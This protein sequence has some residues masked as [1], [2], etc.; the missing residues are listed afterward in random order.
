LAIATL[1]WTFRFTT[2]IERSLKY[3]VR[4]KIGVEDFGLSIRV[5]L[6]TGEVER[7]NGSHGLKGVPDAWPVLAVNDSRA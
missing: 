3:N 4:N 1:P 5:G 6:H 2:L 7:T